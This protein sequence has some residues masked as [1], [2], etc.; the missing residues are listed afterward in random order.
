MMDTDLPSETLSPSPRH[1]RKR[2]FRNDV[3]APR[4]PNAPAAGPQPAPP[5][6]AKASHNQKRLVALILVV[7]V[8][9]SVP[10][11]AL[12]LIFAS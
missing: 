3:P 5:D 8:S 12:T 6:R 10:A 9:I 4:L 11:L 2:R 1:M 7:L